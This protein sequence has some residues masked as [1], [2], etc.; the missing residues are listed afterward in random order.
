[1][2]GLIIK[3]QYLDLILSGEKTWEM[4]ST[5]TKI[6]GRIALIESG[7]GMIMGEVDL[8]D[9]FEPSAGSC[10]RQLTRKQHCLERHERHL[11]DK[12]K[13][14]WVLKGAVRYA[15]PKPYQHPQ[16]AVIWVNL[17]KKL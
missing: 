8:V 15:E 10:D 2:K 9:S 14:A 16:G 3:K 5:Q 11:M 6:R 12:W 17:T 1:M 7:S 4:R 13:Y